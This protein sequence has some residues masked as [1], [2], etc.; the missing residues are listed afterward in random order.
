MIRSIR[1]RPRTPPAQTK[2]LLAVSGI[3][4]CGLRRFWSSAARCSS[5]RINFVPVVQTVRWQGQHARERSGA[6]R[7]DPQQ[8]QA[9]STYRRG[10]NKRADAECSTDLPDE[11]SRWESS[12]IDGRPVRVRERERTNQWSGTGSRDMDGAQ[13][14]CW[15]ERG[16]VSDQL[17]AGRGA[18]HLRDRDAVL[19]HD[20]QGRRDQSHAGTCD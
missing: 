9:K 1:S 19:H 10:Q 5:R 20:S 11:W 8:A 6:H 15:R 18:P 12:D 2:G 17:L 7:N 16:S 4:R 14:G 3:A 13:L